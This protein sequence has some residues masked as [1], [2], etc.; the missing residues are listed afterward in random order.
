MSFL[1]LRRLGTDRTLVLVDGRRHVAGQAGTSAIDINSIPQELV[2]RVEVVTGGASAIYGADAVSGVVNFIMKKDYEG[3]S[4][5]GQAGD[6][7]EGHAL[8]YSMRGTIGGNFNDEKGNAVLTFEVS[9][10]EA[11]VEF[12]IVSESGSHARYQ[13]RRASG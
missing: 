1:D 11:F 12:V 7:S 8:T 2:D 13:S 10:S 3:V 4:L 5:Y 6:A 9:S